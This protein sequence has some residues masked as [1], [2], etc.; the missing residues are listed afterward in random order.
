M[1]PFKPNVLTV[2]IA[3]IFHPKLKVYFSVIDGENYLNH[4]D[5]TF[6]LIYYIKITNSHSKKKSCRGNYSRKYGIHF[7][8]NNNKNISSENK[9]IH[10]L[11]PEED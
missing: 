1:T 5:V 3:F 4:F 9:N 11:N 6:V 7:E 10:G 2:T 8:P